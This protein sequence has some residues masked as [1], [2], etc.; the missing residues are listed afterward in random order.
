MG[1]LRGGG[2]SGRRVT[3]DPVEA[4]VGDLDGETRRTVDALRAAVR[5]VVP[6]AEET[7]L[8]G[9]LSYHSPWI[10]GRVKGAICQITTKQG[11]R[12]EFIHGV[13][14]ADPCGLLQG[15]R[16]S[17]RFVPIVSPA[18]ARR[19]EILNLIRAASEVDFPVAP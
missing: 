18:D 6:D 5:G 2:S 3:R 19:Q 10:G 16:R 8:W 9:G 13:R 4:F 14:L 1:A 12:L 7:V 11:V 17:K 15:T